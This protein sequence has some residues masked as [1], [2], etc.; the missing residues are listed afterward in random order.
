[1]K[2]GMKVRKG[3]RK[4]GT[5]GGRKKEESKKMQKTNK[6]GNVMQYVYQI[7]ITVIIDH[8]NCSFT[9]RQVM[10]DCSC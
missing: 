1:M 8:N 10:K 9:K 2:V 4:K 7:V 3:R 5:E 6:I